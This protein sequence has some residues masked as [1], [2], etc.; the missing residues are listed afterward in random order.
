LK[1]IVARLI[2]MVGG[3]DTGHGITRYSTVVPTFNDAVESPSGLSAL[4]VAVTG[5]TK[6]HPSIPFVGNYYKNEL[7]MEE[8]FKE[9]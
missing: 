7:P 2:A 8:E 3:N 1:D 9:F 6:M 5:K 4:R